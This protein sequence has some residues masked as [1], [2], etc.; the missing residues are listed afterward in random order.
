MVASDTTPASSS[1]AR[2]DATLLAE[3]LITAIREAQGI[4]GVLVR[5]VYLD[6]DAV[7]TRLQALRDEGFDLRIAYLNPDGAPAA[8]RA[9]IP[10]ELFSTAVEDAERWRNEVGLDALVVVITE[11]D[12]AKLTS[13][14]EFRLIGPAQLRRLL[15]DRAASRFDE[16]NDVLPRWWGIIGKDEQ[17]SFFDLVDYFLVLHPLEPEDVKRDSALQINRLGLLPDPAFFDNPGEKQLRA[18]LDENRMLAQRLANFSEEDRQKVD[19]ALADESDPAHRA[20][21][22]SHLRELQEYRRGAQLGLTAID[23]RQLL[24]VRAAK[25][26]KENK[27]DGIGG[28][29]DGEPQPP[30]PSPK[31]L[32]ALAVDVLLHPTAVGDHDTHSD[33]DSG[34]ANGDVGD[35]SAA[36]LDEAMAST[37]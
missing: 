14:E 3:L 22:R 18:R 36:V 15:V 16:I 11:S 17:I 9:G 34:G 27:E 25:P 12:A 5:D 19:K 31:S 4:P 35:T 8:S 7:L 1:P 33:G 29:G 23:A 10:P 28:D 6:P 24:K 13:L 21:L 2:A 37:A 32:T 30:L 20:A 26:T